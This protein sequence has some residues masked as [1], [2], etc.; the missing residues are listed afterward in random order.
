M[1]T[2]QDK[3]IMLLH[4]QIFDLQRDIGEKDKEIEK[5]KSRLSGERHCSQLCQR[6]VH[7]IPYFERY[8]IV[9]KRTSYLCELDN[10][11]KEYKA[12]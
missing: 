4:A 12:K 8:A 3:V 6:C 7:A 10:K 5:L 9:G 2:T 11:C 1:E